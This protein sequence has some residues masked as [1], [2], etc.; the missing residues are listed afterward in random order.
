V[1]TYSP[2]ARG[3]LT[4]KYKTGSAPPEGSRAARG[5]T[6]IHQTELREDS[7]RVAEELTRLAQAKGVT[8]GQLATAWV[9]ANPLVTS[10]VVGPRTF[11]QYLDY[12]KALECKVTA[13]DEAALDRLVPPGEHT[14]KGYTDPN[15]PVRGRPLSG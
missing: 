12:A 6:R 9:L 8:P 10:V 5:D 1:V 11:E 13:E 15:Y 4:G 3:V 2:L 7:F 14:G